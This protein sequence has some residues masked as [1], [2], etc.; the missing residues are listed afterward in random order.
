MNLII[1]AKVKSVLHDTENYKRIVCEDEEQ[2]VELLGIINSEK[3]LQEDLKKAH[4][5]MSQ[6]NT[7]LIQARDMLQELNSALKAHEAISKAG[8]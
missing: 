7:A 5:A 8:K 6:A 2:A 4:A 3:S 1:N